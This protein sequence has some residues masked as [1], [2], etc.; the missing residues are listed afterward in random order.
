MSNPFSGK[1]AQHSRRRE[2]CAH[3]ARTDGH[4]ALRVVPNPDSIFRKTSNH[5]YRSGGKDTL[6]TW[7]TSGGSS[8]TSIPRQNSG[9]DRHAN[10]HSARYAMDHAVLMARRRACAMRY[11]PSGGLVLKEMCRAQCHAQSSKVNFTFLI[12]TVTSLPLLS[13]VANPEDPNE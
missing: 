6:R 10:A 11:G 12:A 1:T 5:L 9:A 8:N 7:A 13:L 3:T 2:A 4:S